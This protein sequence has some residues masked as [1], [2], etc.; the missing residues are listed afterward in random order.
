VRLNK[1]TH[2]KEK[3]WSD[4]K[5]WGHNVKKRSAGEQLWASGELN[6]DKIRFIGQEGARK[7]GQKDCGPPTEF[8]DVQSWFVI[9]GVPKKRLFKNISGGK[10]RK[11]GGG[12]DIDGNRGKKKTM[13]KGP[14]GSK[15]G[16]SS[17]AVWDEA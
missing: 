1:I 14:D 7:S 16:G 17:L 11:P 10:V 15:G 2:K 8:P 13:K 6:S 4:R 3:S 12:L 5:G 9:R